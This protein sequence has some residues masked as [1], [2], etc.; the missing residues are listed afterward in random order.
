M[1]EAEAQRKKEVNERLAKMEDDKEL[2]KK[3]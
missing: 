3:L 2:N 1:R